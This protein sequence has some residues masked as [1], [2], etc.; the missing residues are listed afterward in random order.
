MFLRIALTAAFALSPL[1]AQRFTVTPSTIEGVSLSPTIPDPAA[2]FAVVVRNLG[3]RSIVALVV[4]YE[5]TVNGRTLTHTRS[6]N[7]ISPNFKPGDSET[8]GPSAGGQYAQ[9]PLAI[10]AALD[11]VVF[12]N[13]ELAGP[14]ESG[15]LDRMRQQRASWDALIRDIE[16]LQN[17]DNA[18]LAA[19]LRELSAQQPTES[20]ARMQRRR[21]LDTLNARDASQGRSAVASVLKDLAEAPAPP[22]VFRP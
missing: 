16:A 15:A 14:D 13:G 4:R 8:F 6:R 19:R 5:L 21:W 17:L 3:T 1:A 9:D 10:T 22:Q 7:W 20:F 11:A 2:P 18:A 12:E